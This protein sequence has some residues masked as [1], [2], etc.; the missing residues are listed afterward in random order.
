MIKK[1]VFS[2]HKRWISGEESLGWTGLK[3]TTKEAMNVKKILNLLLLDIGGILESSYVV[4]L[5]P[6]RFTQFCLLVT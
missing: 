6:F 1:I 4:C 3:R 5:F 2:K